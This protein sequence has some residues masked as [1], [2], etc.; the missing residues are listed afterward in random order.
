MPISHRH[1]LPDK[2]AWNPHTHTCIEIGD[3]LCVNGGIDNIGHL[4]HSRTCAHTHTNKHPI[5]ISTCSTTLCCVLMCVRVYVF[6]C[7]LVYVRACV[8]VCVCVCS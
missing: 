1:R 3:I 4:V 5:Y 6:V 2:A 7:A 8:S